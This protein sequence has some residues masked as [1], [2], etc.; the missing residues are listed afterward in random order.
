MQLLM[1]QLN[2]TLFVF[3]VSR[4]DR[5]RRVAAQAVLRWSFRTE[6]LRLGPKRCRADSRDG[7]DAC[8]RAGG[9]CERVLQLYSVVVWL[10]CV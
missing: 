5:I 3:I 9:G 2:L 6:L 1:Q 10:W 4:E 7:E 8:E